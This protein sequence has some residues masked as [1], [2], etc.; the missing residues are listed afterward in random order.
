MREILVPYRSSQYFANATAISDE[1]L[2]KMGNYRK[3]VEGMEADPEVVK[4][5]TKLPA[6]RQPFPPSKNQDPAPSQSEPVRAAPRPPKKPQNTDD[7][8]V[9]S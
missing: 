6:E 5:A 7:V 4:E 1:E 3:F 2:K 9:Q 8:T